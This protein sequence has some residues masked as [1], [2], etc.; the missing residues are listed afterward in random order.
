[1]K[2]CLAI[3]PAR[4]GSKEFLDK[5]IY[6]LCGKPLL[7]YTIEAARISGVFDDVIVS[8]DSAH[9][10][11][12]AENAG[13]QVPFLRSDSLAG[14]T[15]PLSEVTLDVLKRLKD[16]GQKYEY[17]AVLQPTCPLRDAR[18][19]VQAYEM[20]REKDA[21]VVISVREKKHPAYTGGELPATMSL[22]NFIV[23]QYRNVLRQDMKKFYEISG[24]ISFMRVVTYTKNQNLYG[25]KSY[26]HVLDPHHALDIDSAIDFA[27]AQVLLR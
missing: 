27:L 10:A 16:M 17:C 1:M 25:S 23:K 9:Y 2:Q 13:A 26:A 4:S 3:I 7:S 20:L 15:V 8:T 5:N 24:A 14:D 12:I 18:D 11:K 21:D 6:P 19:I 22:D